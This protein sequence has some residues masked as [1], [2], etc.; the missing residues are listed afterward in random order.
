MW[1]AIGND[2]LNLNNIAGVHFA[3]DDDGVLTATIETFAG[4]VK[5]YR[6]P[7]AIALRQTL[8]NLAAGPTPPEAGG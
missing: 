3:S 5:H 6:G 1:I 8:E 4:N 2:F 7:D